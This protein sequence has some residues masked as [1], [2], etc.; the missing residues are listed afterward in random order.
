[1]KRSNHRDYWYWPQCDVDGCEGVSSANGI[2]WRP[3]YWC[4]CSE[5]HEAARAGAEMP[6]MKAR[7]VKREKS[8]DAS[9]CLK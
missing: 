1:M 8:R 6:K 2:Y 7:A 5:H 3:G 4:L 9:G